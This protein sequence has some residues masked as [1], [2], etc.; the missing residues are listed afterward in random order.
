MRLVENNQSLTSE[1]FREIFVFYY[2]S[3]C[4]FSELLV[5]DSVIA[6]ECVQTVFMHIWE[7][8]DHIKFEKK[9][10]SYLFRSVYNQSI[11]MIKRREVE[12]KSIE[13]LKL[14]AEAL[15]PV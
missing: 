1:I 6:E 10:K 3:L 14:I 15:T 12:R 13:I 11:N 2:D 8:R 4:R 5:K 9:V 7:K